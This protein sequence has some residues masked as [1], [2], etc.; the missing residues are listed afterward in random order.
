MQRE[1]HIYHISPG[2]VA[3]AILVAAFFVVLF[4]L[5]DLMLVVLAAVVTASAV[6]PITR[7]FMHFRIGRLPAVIFIYV[8]LALLLVGIFSFLIIP[9]LGQTSSLLNS[10]PDYLG[11]VQNWQPFQGPESGAVA[12]EMSLV[13]DLSKNLPLQDIALKFN[14]LLG[15]L[16]SGFW[17]TASLAF[18]GLLSFFLIIVLSFYLAVQDHGILN[19]LSVITPAKYQAYILDLWRRAEIK[20]GLWMQGQL[21]LVIIVGVLVYLG[22]TL[23]GVE[24]ALPLAVIAGF[25]EIIPVFGPILASIPAVALGFVEGGLSM[26]VLVAGLYLII[27]QF[28]NQLIYPLV[29]KKVV[30]VPPVVVMLALVAGGQ[31]AG[32]LGVLLSV[33]LAAVGMEIFNDYQKESIAVKLKEPQSSVK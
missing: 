23:I 21:L 12:T 4:L 10:L 19:F 16:S 15:N 20:I 28:E 1:A 13:S 26:G 8:G 22:L 31:L 3:K 2:S 29:V 18:G 17:S 6:E 27:Q 11:N 14:E 24:H 9:L 33:P 32:F 25:F 5:R 30:G 7:W